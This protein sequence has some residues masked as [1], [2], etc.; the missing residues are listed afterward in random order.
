MEL[1]KKWLIPL[2]LIVAAAF[3]LLWR[4]E[5]QKEAPIKSDSDSLKSVIVALK[6]GIRIK[7]NELSLTRLKLSHQD[8]SHEEIKKEA[9]SLPR[10]KQILK[11][12]GDSILRSVAT[13]KER[14]LD[15]SLA[16]ADTTF[17]LL[18]IEHREQ[19]LKD[20]LV[21]QVFEMDST[22]ILSGDNEVSSLKRKVKRRNTLIKV[23]G[24]ALFALLLLWLAK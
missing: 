22:L 7:D 11:T 6:C 3:F 9:A 5:R 1:F 17:K 14:L 2:L 20:S 19:V 8:S 21:K 16:I 10:I 12:Q 18:K 13:E 4:C 15:S 24:L 23:E